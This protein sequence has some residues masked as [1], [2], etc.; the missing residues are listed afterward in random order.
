MLIVNTRKQNAFQPFSSDTTHARPLKRMNPT[1]KRHIESKQSQPQDEDSDF[2]TSFPRV[3]SKRLQTGEK[4]IHPTID[5]RRGFLQNLWCP[6]ET[7]LADEIKDILE[8]YVVGCNHSIS[9]IRQENSY[10]F[11]ASVTK[12]K[13]VSYLEGG[14]QYQKRSSSFALPTELYA[15]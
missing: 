6:L 2:E 11:S 10:N 14:Y 9:H 5:K 3:F 15:S 1:D 13:K 12:K 7:F 4:E 8:I